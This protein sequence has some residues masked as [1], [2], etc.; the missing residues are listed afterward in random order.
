MLKGITPHAI[1]TM[2]IKLFYKRV[3]QL[4]KVHCLAKKK[5]KLARAAHCRV[6]YLVR[7]SRDL[8]KGDPLYKGFTNE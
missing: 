2:F 8:C 1:M 6:L 4:N 3:L 7:I 5:N